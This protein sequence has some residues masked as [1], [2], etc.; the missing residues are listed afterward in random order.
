MRTKIFSKRSERC[1]WSICSPSL[2]CVSQS[3]FQCCMYNIIPLVGRFRDLPINFSDFDNVFQKFNGS[4]VKWLS[5]F[6]TKSL[7][8]IEWPKWM[9]LQIGWL[10]HKNYMAIRPFYGVQS[11]NQNRFCIMY[12]LVCNDYLLIHFEEHRNIG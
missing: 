7:L 5:S 9:E 4:C 1:V 6:C 3:T 8:K 11:C 12:S 2:Q 10:K